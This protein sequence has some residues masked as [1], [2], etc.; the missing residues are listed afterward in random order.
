[1]IAIEAFIEMLQK[2]SPRFRD[3]L[4]A[5]QVPGVLARKRNALTYPTI[6]SHKTF[7][8]IPKNYYKT[9]SKRCLNHPKKEANRLKNLQQSTNLSILITAARLISRLGPR[10]SWR[11][12]NME[13]QKPPP[14]QI[15]RSYPPRYS[16]K[17]ATLSSEEPRQ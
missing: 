13:S 4:K 15:L 14:R 3:E 2:S 8:I 9:Y 12:P 10:P 17:E 16:P 11:M 7:L 1:M 6:G 5:A